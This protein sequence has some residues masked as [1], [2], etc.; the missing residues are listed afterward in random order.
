MRKAVI[1][2][3]GGLDSATVIGIA[4]DQ[5]YALYVL[6]FDYGQRHSRE[7]E[8][9]SKIAEFYQIQEHK[10]INIDLGHLGG[11]A[12][13]DDN[14]PVPEGRELENISE[15]IPSTYVPA[16][17]TIFISYGLAY[18]EIIDADAIYIGA[19]ARDYSGYPDCRPEYFNIFQQLV[20]LC[21]KR[22]V[23]GRPIELKTPLIDMTKAEIIKKGVEL[24][25]PYK[26]TWSCY[27]GGDR[28]CGICDS[29]LLR[30]KGFQEAGIDDPSLDNGN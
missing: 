27:K 3:S 9:A 25:V 28:P 17:N 29:C 10:I 7:L 30:A 14:I 2:L 12:L 21:N 24:G 1:L 22:G 5:G 13:T 20:N 8:C 4:H 16:R 23:E 19:N 11:S 18:A 15:T 6:S 26:H